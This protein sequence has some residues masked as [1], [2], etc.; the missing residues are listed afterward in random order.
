MEQR[1]IT[2]TDI[3]EVRQEL[4]DSCYGSRNMV[5]L[6]RLSRLYFD[7]L[8]DDESIAKASFDQCVRFFLQCSDRSV[9]KI[10]LTPNG[11]LHAHWRVGTSQAL[12]REFTGIS[13]E[14]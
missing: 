10:T 13:D 4:L 6:A 9:P 12:S 1:G 11:T 2:M 5:I 7:A 3:N 8:V 14:S